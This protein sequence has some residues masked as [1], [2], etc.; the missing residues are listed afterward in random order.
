MDQDAFPWLQ[1]GQ[2]YQ[3]IPRSQEGHGNGGRLFIGQVG[4]DRGHLCSGQG[5]IAGKGTLN[6]R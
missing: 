6:R 5:E 4:G 1:L 3:P 2:L